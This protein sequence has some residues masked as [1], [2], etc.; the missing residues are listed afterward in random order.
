LATAEE[1]PL[2]LRDPA[3]DFYVDLS[4]LGTAWGHLDAGAMTDVALQFVE[5][6]RVLLRPHK[7]IATCDLLTIAMRLAAVKH[8]EAS[9]ER[10]ATIVKQRDNATLTAKL[11]EAKKLLAAMPKVDPALTVSIA[12]LNINTFTYYKGCLQD[13]DAAIVVQ[14]PAL[15]L[16]VEKHLAKVKTLPAEH[17]AKLTSKLAEAKKSLP[18]GA[19]TALAAGSI[20]DKLAAATRNWPP[21]GT[22]TIPSDGPHDGPPQDGPPHDGPPHDGPPHD[23]PPRWPDWPDDGPP[24]TWRPPTTTYRP[25]TGKYPPQQQQQQWIPSR[26]SKPSKPGKPGKGQDQSDDGGY[27]PWWPGGSQGE[28]GGF[29]RRYGGW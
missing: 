26:P 3:F 28:S 15:L 6:E 21:G 18:E 4:L 7:V 22:P 14:D 29:S 23:G 19:K 17:R 2:E 8:D 11:A 1:V 16:D 27:Y 9:L 10:L 25:P 5:G 24:W 20:L 12:D 13:I